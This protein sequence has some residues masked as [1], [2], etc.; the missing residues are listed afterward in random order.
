MHR[1]TLVF[2]ATIL[3]SMAFLVPQANAGRA[4][5]KSAYK[6]AVKLANASDLEG[7]VDSFAKA[8]REDKK[9]GQAWRDLGMA[10]RM[11][12]RHVEA[13]AAY[14]AATKLSKKSHT[15]FL[16][17]GRCYLAL[18]LPTLAV[19]ALEKAE[20][21]AKKKSKE[22]KTIKKYLA[23]ASLEAGDSE[24]AVKILKKLHSA[25]PADQDT[26]SKLADAQ[27]KA[28]RWGG[29][30]ISLKKLTKLNA[31]NKT[32]W[33]LMAQCQTQLGDTAAAKEAYSAA[34]DLGD[35]KACLRAR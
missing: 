25:S 27:S 33:L 14:Q 35:R 20:K 28:K 15:A 1:K 32:A 31:A 34:C 23:K 29:A 4:A 13:L 3:F 12:G 22:L 2:A 26:L 17:L 11:K 24:R 30:V 8:V 21:K 7:A 10:L 19:S 9:Y 6:R 18:R 5:A 16:G